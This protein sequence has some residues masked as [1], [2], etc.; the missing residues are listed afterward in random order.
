MND[1]VSVII[2]TYNRA[3]LVARAIRSA[4]ATIRPGDEILVIDDGST[5]NTE[6]VVRSF[7][8]PMRYHRVANG[9]PGA[10]RNAGIRLAQHDLLAFL[11]S[12]DEFYP[13]KLFLQRQVMQKYPNLVLSFGNSAYRGN[14]G[15]LVG[16]LMSTYRTN[17]YIGSPFPTKDAREIL[18]PAIPFSSVC[19]LPEGC[20]DF[21]IQIGKFGREMMDAYYMHSDAVLVR[22]SNAGAACAYIEDSPLMDDWE[23]MIGLA[24]KGP[25]AFLDR[26]VA[27]MNGHDGPRIV[28][29]H[30]LKQIDARLRVLQRC[31]G[32]ELGEVDSED[33]TRYDALMR[34]YRLQRGKALLGL[35]K[36]TEARAEFDA[37]GA[38]LSYRL[39]T[40]L[41]TFVALPLYRTQLGLKKRMRQIST[42]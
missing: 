28:Y 16:D 42:N 19:E 9:G 21:S 6:E 15:V 22:R 39:F 24:R 36:L 40:R 20:A 23:F 13:E 35:E 26:D 18:G 11:D 4:L 12:D 17:E 3:I 31:F 14:D 1:D 5:D 34:F 41:P 25:V 8:G 32:A 29:V 2:P 38:S 37:A 30:P 10:A 33:R 7:G 27:I